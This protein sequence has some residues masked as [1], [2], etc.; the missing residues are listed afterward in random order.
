MNYKFVLI[1]IV[2]VMVAGC[3]TAPIYNVSDTTVVVAAGKQASMDDVKTAI[4][5]AGNRLGWQ[6]T[7]TAPGVITARIA[8]RTHTATAEVRFSAQTYSIKYVDSTNLDAKG[9][10][11]HKNYNGWIENLNTEIRTEL[12]RT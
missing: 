7:D 9:G 5:R 6:M 10:N 3:R 8:L 2:L 1:A 4:M 11:I 12:L